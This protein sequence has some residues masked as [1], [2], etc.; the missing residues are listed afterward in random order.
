[1]DHQR[2]ETCSETK[3]VINSIVPTAIFLYLF[4][5]FKL[6]NCISVCCDKV[7]HTY[8]IKSLWTNGVEEVTPQGVIGF[9]DKMQLILR[10]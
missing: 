8:E 10:V 6:I 7:I 1:M 2:A 3:S 4:V 9:R 5:D